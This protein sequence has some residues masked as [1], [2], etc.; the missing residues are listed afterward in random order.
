MKILLV[1]P[2]MPSTFWTFDHAVELAGKQACYPPLGLLTVAAMLPKTWD[3]RL[4]DLNVGQELTDEALEWADFVFLGAMNVQVRSAREIVAQCNRAG[5]KVVAGGPLF[6]HEYDTFPTVDH[7]VLNEA[8]IT[9]P[10]FLADLEAGAPKPLYATPDFANV[11]ETPIPLWE[12]ADLDKYVFA[13]VQYSRGCPYMCDFCDVTA[14]FGRKPRIKKPEQMLAELEALGDLGRFDMVLFADDN[15]IGNKAH[16]KKELLPAL[17]DWRMRAPFRVNFGT[18]VTVNLVDDEVLTRMM[19]EAGFGSIFCG[20]E[21]PDEETLKATNKRQ[22]T[23]RDLLG[24]VQK[25]HELGF[26]ISAG[27]IVGFDT[28]TPESFQRMIDFIQESGIVIATVNLLKAPPGTELHARIKREGRLIEPFNFDENESNIVPVM[29]P[30]TLHEGFDYVLSHVYRPALVYARARAFLKPYQTTPPQIR[31]PGRKGSPFP[32]RRDWESLGRLVLAIGIRGNAR[33]EFW[34]F[35]LW[36]LFNRPAKVRMALMLAT[37][38]YQLE[39]MYDRYDAAAEARKM[40]V[41]L[42][43]MPVPVAAESVLQKAEAG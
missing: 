18:Q 13:I 42:V 43:E 39:K 41:A 2:K 19:L 27:F 10:L 8:E 26:T 1:Y 32:K 20:L 4:I 23:K 31:K 28:D 24:N 25:L 35:V 3:K 7:F 21:S 6:T 22:N 30:R 38:A 5:V 16:L 11:H 12:L 40:E 14:L 17:I 34:K 33:W 29:D 37:M 9:L 15:L 36:T